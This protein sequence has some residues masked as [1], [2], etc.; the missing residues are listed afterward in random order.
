MLKLLSRHNMFV[1]IFYI[2]GFEQDTLQSIRRDIAALS[3]LDFDVCQVQVLTPYPR[4]KQRDEIERKFGIFDKNLSK[5]NSR[6]LV[7][8]HP[9]ISPLEMRELQSWANNRIVTTR[10]TLRTL[11]K[12]AIFNGKPSPNLEGI[13]MVASLFGKQSR[14]MHKEYA[15]KMCSARK[16]AERGWFAYEECNTQSAVTSQVTSI[17]AE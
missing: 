15:R 14:Q 10:R 1:Q 17:A 5:Y 13:R 16:W 6:N 4:T 12:L 7:W 11:S 2:L 8:N 9:H 3:Q